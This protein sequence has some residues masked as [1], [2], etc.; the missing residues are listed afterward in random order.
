MKITVVGLGYV[1][2]VAA[3]ALAGAGHDVL[4]IDIDRSRTDLLNRGEVPLYEPG[5]EDRIVAALALQVRFDLS[6]RDDVAES[7]WATWRSS[8]PERLRRTGA[9]PTC[10]RSA[11]LLAG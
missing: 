2:T 1:G 10:T 5:L 7:L 9:G 4:G 11:L 8:Q 3:A 6:H